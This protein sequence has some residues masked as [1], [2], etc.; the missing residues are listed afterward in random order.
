MI[1]PPIQNR[2]NAILFIT[3]SLATG[4][5]AGIAFPY[6]RTKSYI[7][8]DAQSTLQKDANRSSGDGQ[9]RAE[10]TGV[11]TPDSLPQRPSD[12]V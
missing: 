8:H 12:T 1:C 4:S 10:G 2:K 9:K 6:L 11:N 5:P 3:F 7:L